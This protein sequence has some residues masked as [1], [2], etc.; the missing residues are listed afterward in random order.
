MI[1]QVV[2]FVIRNIYIYIGKSKKELEKK[3]LKKIQNVS[4]NLQDDFH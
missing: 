2:A 4:C 3:D 1:K